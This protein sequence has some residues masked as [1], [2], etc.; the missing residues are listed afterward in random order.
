[1]HTRPVIG[2]VGGIGSGKSEVARALAALGC[3]VCVS[4]DLARAVLDEPSVRAAIAAA[5]P[6]AALADGSIDR[7][8]LGRA[9]F[10]DRSLRAHIESIMHP[11][12]EARRRAQFTAAPASVR[13][14][15]IDAPLLL[16]VGLDRECDAVIF[17][18]APEAHRLA[19]VERSRG[20][21]AAEL[22]RRESA[23][24]PLDEKRRRAT[25]TVVNDGDRA[26]LARQVDSV[27]G[28]ILAAPRARP[29]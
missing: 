17:V 25:H 5:C 6:A 24:L 22:A 8:A 10:T 18:D 19:R 15:V 3:E 13:A 26:A 1:M 27:L 20:W 28:G 2:I 23:Q 7:A 16:E 9:I 11:R 4:D 21:D 12:I 29:T 14:F